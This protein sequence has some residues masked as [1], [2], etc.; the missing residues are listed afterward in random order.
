MATQTHHSYPLF[1]KNQVLTHSQLNLLASYLEEQ[2][3][4]TRSSLIGIGIVC[5][6]NLKFTPKSD[7]SIN[8]D[9][10]YLSKGVGITSMGHLITLC[11][12]E[13][14]KIRKYNIDD[15]V[16]YA[17]FQDTDSGEQDVALWELLSDDFKSE[18]DNGVKSLKKADLKDKVVLLFIEVFDQ[19]LKS[20]LSQGCDEIGV[21]RKLNIRKLLI[22]KEDLNKVK[23]R[24]GG[25]KADQP[26]PEK[27]ELP[28]LYLKRPQLL[29]DSPATGSYIG[30]SMEYVQA[31]KAIWND[32]FSILDHSYS[33]YEPVL[34]DL[35]GENPFKS[36]AIKQARFNLEEYIKSSENFSDP[37]YGAQYLYGFVKDL[38]MA[39]EEFRMA[40]FEISGICSPDR[41]RFPKHLMLGEPLGDKP[42]LCDPIEFRH[43]FSPSPALTDQ[44]QHVAK[45]KML[46]KRLV[47]MLECVDTDRFDHHEKRKIKITPSIEKQGPLGD[48]SIPIYYDSK[49]KSSFIKTESLEN[50][51]NFDLQRQCRTTDYPQQLSY[52]NHQPNEEKE[53]P[54]S[55]PL[56]FDLDPFNFFRIEGHFGKNLEEASG[57]IKR[58]QQ[59]YNLSF[60]IKT[61][62]F[63]DV[64]ETHKM[65]NCLLEDLQPRYSIWRN[66]ILLLVKNIVKTSETVERIVLSRRMEAAEPDATRFASAARVAF[67]PLSGLDPLRG[68][69]INVSDLGN[70][71]L[72]ADAKEFEH[73]SNRLFK[74]LKT[75]EDTGR[76][77]EEEVDSNEKTAEDDDLKR[78]FAFFN[79]CLHKMMDAMSVHFDTFQMHEWLEHYKCTLRAFVNVMKAL[80]KSAAPHGRQLLMTLVYLLLL[81]AIF[82]LITFLAIYPY[83]T[84]RI[85]NDTANRRRIAWMESLQVSHFRENHPGM[86]HKAGVAPGQTFL[87]VYQA[88]HNIPELKKSKDNLGIDKID[89]SMF[90]PGLVKKDRDKYLKY[91]HKMTQMVVADF[92]L[93]FICCDECDDVVTVE[94][95]I[96]P[97][98]PP[99]TA[100]VM[101]GRSFDRTHGDLKEEDIGYRNVEVQLVNNLYDPEIYEPEIPGNPEYGTVSFRDDQYEPDH[102]K[103]KK[104]LVYEVD[105]DKVLKKA[106]KTDSGFIIDEF[107]YLIKNIIE[108]NEVDRDRITIFIPVLRQEKPASGR[109]SG[110]VRGIKHE[111]DSPVRG[112]QEIPLAEATVF[113]AETGE[114]TVTNKTGK[115]S[116]DSVDLGT[117]NLRA[118]HQDFEPASEAVE[119]KPGENVVDFLLKP[120]IIVR[121]DFNN[122]IDSMDLNISSD[123]ARETIDHHEAI[124]KEANRKAVDLAITET[125]EDSP[126][127]K[128]A[129]AIKDFTQKED[130]SE[131]QL[132]SEFEK[133]KN[134]LVREI[135]RSEGE[136]KE[137][138]EAA[139]ENLTTVY[140]DR[141]AISQPT[142]F[143]EK[144]Q[145]VMHQIKELSNDQP[146]LGNAI[147]NWQDTSANFVTGDFNHNFL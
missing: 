70:L 54:I 123:K 141:I 62:Y 78:Q 25:G 101:P 69:D 79:D 109:I 39:Y 44:H 72:R 84:I 96:R 124:F 17:P 7:P 67:D 34:K 36:D 77:L 35:Y 52:D 119:V 90:P 63:G 134:E 45:L 71:F 41:F 132:N 48:R 131:D 11:D 66:R 53:N 146:E 86:E 40:G 99:V 125:K 103:N 129:V 20:C 37:V 57:Q 8:K 58:I 105:R 16:D 24:T 91:V 142:E 112:I 51:W 130:I 139:L 61:I 95:K 80:A 108:D 50:V 106:E 73:S 147:K 138:H 144:T 23:S 76:K 121:I 30:L 26:F 128:T 18:E 32:L 102:S 145:E 2:D 111:R 42:G 28:S 33:V 27:I 114:Q 38:L 135:R 10:I 19:N 120:E 22:S 12:C 3:R 94:E 31:V 9:T 115:Y 14:T 122:F 75:V 29:P 117:Y 107:D 143:S 87:L 64:V 136:V 140:M 13:I 1:E 21:E 60:D 88:G 15:Y 68:F 118:A 81:S 46:H 47:L 83:I 110:T 56:N 113:I 92:T 104:I 97:F 116:F 133:L 89:S 4:L 137:R 5:G 82:G 65:P 74:L 127:I 49:R 100:V 126:I 43:V 85:L 98:A 55:T 6:F 93:P 59:K